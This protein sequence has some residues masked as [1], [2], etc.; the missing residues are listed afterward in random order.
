[1]SYRHTCR[2]TTSHPPVPASEGAS[3]FEAKAKAKRNRKD[4]DYDSDVEE[5]RNSGAAAGAAGAGNSES[6]NRRKKKLRISLIAAPDSAAGA[7]AAASSSALPAA[8]SHPLVRVQETTGPYAKANGNHKD[9][10]PASGSAPSSAASAIELTADLN[11]LLARAPAVV[12]LPKLTRLDTDRII[13]WDEKKHDVYKCCMCFF[14][15]LEP[16]EILC[17]AGCGTLCCEEDAKTWFSR[18]NLSC[19]HCRGNVNTLNSIAYKAT[20]AAAKTV[21]CFDF[22]CYVCEQKVN[23]GKNGM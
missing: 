9:D 19:P 3:T 16:V 12:Q 21:G 2:K 23:V 4:D 20:Q 22:Q 17:T 1:M 10:R 5:I 6:L 15:P 18:G 7:G 11:D 8:G 14:V 13:D